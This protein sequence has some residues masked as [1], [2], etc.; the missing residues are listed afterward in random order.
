MNRRT[1][2]VTLALLALVAIWAV[3]SGGYWIA[4]KKKVTGEKVMAYMEQTDLANLQ[5]ADRARKLRELVDQLNHLPYEERRNVRLNGQWAR[6][7]EA[8]TEEEKNQFLEATVPTGFKQAITAFEQMPEQKRKKT[9]DDAYKRLRVAQEEA[10]KGQPLRPPT[11]PRL[12]TNAPVLD[13]QLRQKVTGIGL[14][15]FLKESSPKTRAE[16]MPLLEEMQRTM[17]RAGGR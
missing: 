12:G 8:M 1:K 5:G 11:D 16:V 3:A 10:A 2:T 4:R 17:Q 6:W 7:F 13:D 15:T 9:I 14:S